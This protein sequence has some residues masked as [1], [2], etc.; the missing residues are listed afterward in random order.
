[1][2]DLAVGESEPRGRILDA[3]QRC[4]GAEGFRGAS[5]SRIA[6][7]A[8]ISVGHIYRYFENKE[9][10]VAAIVRRDLDE[11][12]Q[13][14]EGLK[15]PPEAQAD[16]L[17]ADL[18]RHST[19]ERLALWL[20]VIAEAA[21][22]PGVA[23]LVREADAELRSHLSGVLARSAPP[24]MDPCAIAGRAELLCMVIEGAL[25]RSARSCCPQALSQPGLRTLLLSLLS[26]DDAPA[27]V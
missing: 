16:R 11:T 22:N 6:A 17:L 21:R 2:A 1:M 24:Q 8:R 4:F 15:G 14:M 12:R 7:A 13:E 10:V 9:A 18:A 20:E 19:S 5:M 23:D 3:S 25:V 26:W 27:E